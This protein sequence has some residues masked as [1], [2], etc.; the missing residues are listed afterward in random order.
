MLKK[1][2]NAQRNNKGRVVAWNVLVAI[3]I[4][5]SWTALI[6]CGAAMH[7]MKDQGYLFGDVG[8]GQT[9]IVF[10]GAM[11][12]LAR[13]HSYI[14]I[15]P[16][17]GVNMDDYN[18]EHLSPHYEVMTWDDYGTEYDGFSFDDI[19][20]F[21]DK[22]RFCVD[23]RFFGSDPE[24][25]VIIAYIDGE[26][27]MVYSNDIVGKRTVSYDDIVAFVCANKDS[28][29]PLGETP[30]AYKPPDTLIAYDLYYDLE[31]ILTEYV[32]RNF[33]AK[34]LVNYQTIGDNFGKYK[35][36]WYEC[37]LTYMHAPSMSDTLTMKVGV[38]VSIRE[39]AIRTSPAIS[40]AFKI[41]NFLYPL[42]GT[43]FAATALALAAIVVLNLVAARFVGRSKL[44]RFMQRIFGKV[45]ISLLVLALAACAAWVYIAVSGNIDVFVLSL[46]AAAVMFELTVYCAVC[47]YY[48]VPTP[49]DDLANASLIGTV[50]VV[51]A[52]A[53][54]S[55]VVLVSGLPVLVCAWAVMTAAVVLWMV[56]SLIQLGRLYLQIKSGE[57]QVSTDGICRLLK[58]HSMHVRSMGERIVHAV[59]E[60][61][62]SERM[63]TELITNVSHDIKTPL[64]SIVN[65]IGLLGT[66]HIQSET[67]KGYL[68]VLNRQ[69]NRLKRLVEDLVE[70][71][72]AV[73]G[74]ITPNFSVVNIKELV[75]QAAAEY[76]DRFESS[77]IT[78]VVTAAEG[79]ISAIADGRL[80]WRVIDNL[81]SNICK[82]A[83]PGT[84]AYLHSEIV[85]DEVQITV[86]NISAHALNITPDELVKRFVRGDSSRTLEG[87]G[88]GLSIAKSLTELQSGDFNIAIDGDL[89][90]V[91]IRLERAGQEAGE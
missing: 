90:K 38:C 33:G 65:Y 1:A 52:Y 15:R 76:I 29:S 12:I 41:Y 30:W 14:E 4:L 23:G 68:E 27:R 6:L 87:S 56:C 28:L 78:P 9:E 59:N 17:T 75:S 57:T 45:P 11:D 5:V 43:I 85:D 55:V 21:I 20:Y 47:R 49:K 86:K 40:K 74:T 34:K 10:D 39:G 44:S 82:Y 54:I 77:E 84:R 19:M 80:L 60:Q 73:S 91:I 36:G 63:Q 79:D 81:M 18:L 24:N 3:L 22:K 66:E 53:A 67:G 32:T 64:T 88:L 25:E 48:S 58:S 61:V 69:A 7:H 72:K 46:I 13:V 62:K 70:A 31:Y 35:Q 8:F 16:D 2:E 37:E 51:C 26:E 50:I 42:R 71:A 83:Q 89:F